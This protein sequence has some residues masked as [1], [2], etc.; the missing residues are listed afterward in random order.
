[1]LFR[2]RRYRT[3]TDNDGRFEFGPVPTG[4]HEISVAVERVPLPWGL[5]DESPRRADVPLRGAA[6]VDIPLNRLNQ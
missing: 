6:I 4:A 5:L 3:V 1:M 2:S